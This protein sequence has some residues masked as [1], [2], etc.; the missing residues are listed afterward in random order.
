MCRSTRSIRAFKLVVEVEFDVSCIDSSEEIGHG[1]EMLLS[2][3]RLA[4]LF[5]RTGDELPRF[6]R[7][8]S[9]F[10][11]AIQ[12]LPGNAAPA[13]AVV[14]FPLPA[15]GQYV[16]FGAVLAAVKRPWMNS[17]LEPSRSGTT[18]NRS[19]YSC[20]RENH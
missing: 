15:I 2:H 17:C 1:L 16:I 8:S 11:K 7:Y 19:T 20:S 18:W 10:G 3:L 5:N 13:R 6:D 12:S 4:R 14:G 9:P